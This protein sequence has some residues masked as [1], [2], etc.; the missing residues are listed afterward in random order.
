MFSWMVHLLASLWW[1]QAVRAWSGPVATGGNDSFRF[2]LIF[3]SLVPGSLILCL[4]LHS[5]SGT[6]DLFF[7][8]FDIQVSTHSFLFLCW[9]HVQSFLIQLLADSFLYDNGPF[10]R[11][12]LNHEVPVSRL[13]GPCCPRHGHPCLPPQGQWSMPPGILSQRLLCYCYR[14]GRSYGDL[15]R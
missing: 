7:L 9:L 14:G 4:S 1:A 5:L 15:V 3:Y 12:T 8:G 2:A 10:L 13:S 6:A 11:H